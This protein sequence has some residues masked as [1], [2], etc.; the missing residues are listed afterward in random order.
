[1]DDRQKDRGKDLV[2]IWHGGLVWCRACASRDHFAKASGLDRIERRDVEN[3]GH[4][5][6]DICGDPLYRDFSGSCHG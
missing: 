5:Y 2:G 6:C 1:M 4:N 3:E